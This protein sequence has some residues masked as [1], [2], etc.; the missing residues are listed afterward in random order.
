MQNVLSQSND[1]SY[2]PTGLHSDLGRSL[3]RELRALA[4]AQMVQESSG[5]TLQATALVH[6]A[7]L[8]LGQVRETQRDKFLRIAATTMRRVLVDHARKR[9]SRK[10]GGGAA[11]LPLEKIELATGEPPVDLLELDVALGELEQ[12]DPRAFRIVEL[13]FFGGLES[14]EVA[15]ML[16][17]SERTIKRE[18]ASARLWLFDRMKGGQELE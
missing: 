2:P 8:R 4:L 7:W 15:E 13:R 1:A 12:L 18:W 9:L 17:L 6:E 10:R 14:R 5:H 3:Y 11:R 16:A